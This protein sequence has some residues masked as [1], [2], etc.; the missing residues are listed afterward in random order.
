MANSSS[1]TAF[2]SQLIFNGTFQGGW[3][4][5]DLFDLTSLYHYEVADKDRDTDKDICWTLWC[6]CWLKGMVFVSVQCS[7][8]WHL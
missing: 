2:L 6:L 4:W 5:K 8:V 7:A 3:G 1:F